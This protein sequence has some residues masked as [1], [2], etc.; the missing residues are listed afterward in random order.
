MLLCE[1]GTAAGWG[2]FLISFFL[3]LK[4]LIDT[5]IFLLGP[6]VITLPLIIIFTGRAVGGLT[7]GNI[8]V[9]NAYI[10]DVTDDKDLNRNFGKMSVAANL[11]FIAG[12]A[13]SGILGGTSLEE[14]LPV[15]AALLIS[16]SAI[17]VILFF[18]KDSKLCLLRK[19]PAVR[20]F[21][22]FWDTKI[23]SALSSTA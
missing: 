22:K 3:P 4:V 6:V 19:V 8:S 10:A 15:M 16:I 18:L 17:F 13:L 21:R 2:N 5:N 23:K 1:I 9:A 7:G 12:P 11:G 20:R 14:M